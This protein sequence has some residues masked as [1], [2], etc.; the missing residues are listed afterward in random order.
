MIRF[1]PRLWSNT[2]SAALLAGALAACSPGGEAGET[3]K[4][5]SE[6]SVKG[7][8]GGEVGGEGKASAIASG[9]S[10]PNGEGGAG[11][12][13]A[14]TAY[15]GLPP[16][17]AFALRL[18]HIRGFILVSQAA[19]ADGKAPEEAS[20]L[21]GQGM[22]EAY[23]PARNQFAAETAVSL[24]TATN[25]LI[26]ALDSGADQGTVKKFYAKVLATLDT[27][28][29]DTIDTK[30]LVEGMLSISTGLYAGVLSK[31]G[32][33]D[34]IE[35]QHSYGAALAAR[36]ALLVGKDHLSAKNS[37]RF[38]RTLAELDQHLALWGGPI[39][40]EKPTPLAEIQAQASRIQ[41]ALSGL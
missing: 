40:P 18:E 8:H 37:A 29:P 22:L 15:N 38:Q 20:A 19:Y 23:S 7:Q 5:A 14:A 24:E 39:A 32:D 36:H 11:E 34:P 9:V 12:A 33:V 1:T 41:L 2:G 3:G 21:V 35:F 27:A 4:A 6:A 31:E 25:T 16:D 13:G 17:A 30:T 10:A 28:A 26:T